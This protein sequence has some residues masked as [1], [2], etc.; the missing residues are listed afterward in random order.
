MSNVIECVMLQG[1]PGS[2]KSTLTEKLVAITKNDPKITTKV[3]CVT[4][5]FYRNGVYTFN[6]H[7]LSEYYSRLMMEFAVDTTLFLLQRQEDGELGEG[8]RFIAYVD[9]MNI[10]HYAI[11]P[12]F[13]WVKRLQMANQKLPMNF[14][15]VEPETDWRYDPAECARRSKHSATHEVCQQAFLELH[16]AKHF[17][18]A[19]G[20]VI[21]QYDQYTLHR[22]PRHGNLKTN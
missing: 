1:I 18:L 9:N 3:Y 20:E 10:S 8:R 7:K 16:K 5:H 17:Q 11:R 21:N 2:G 13:E 22:N 15:I 14:S 19:S 12:Y 4:D 6:R